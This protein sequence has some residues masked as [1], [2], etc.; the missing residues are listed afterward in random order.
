MLCYKYTEITKTLYLLYFII[1]KNT[2]DLVNIRNKKHQVLFWVCFVVY[3]NEMRPYTCYNELRPRKINCSF[4]MLSNF[5]H[6]S[7]NV[8][9]LCT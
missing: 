5:F 8:Y 3:E 2:F 6:F 7:F 4:I 9:I 1:Y